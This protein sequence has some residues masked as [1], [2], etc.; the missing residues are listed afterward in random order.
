M[1][2][3]HDFHD[4]NIADFLEIFAAHRNSP[5]WSIACAECLLHHNKVQ[6][7]LFPK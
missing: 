5:Y 6:L 1:P 2:S 4:T 3:L 7:M